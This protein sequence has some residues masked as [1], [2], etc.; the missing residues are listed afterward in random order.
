MR[1][2]SNLKAAALLPETTMENH[3]KGF[4]AVKNNQTQWSSYLDMTKRYLLI[5]NDLATIDELDPYALSKKE[6]A[7]LKAANSP[8]F[9]IMK[10]VCNT[11]Q[12]QHGTLHMAWHLFDSLLTD[13]FQAYDC[14]KEYLAPTAKIVC[15]PDFESGVVKIMNGQVLTVAEEAACTKLLKKDASVVSM[16]DGEEDTLEPMT[17]MDKINQQVES[18]VKRQKRHHNQVKS[19]SNSLYV[20]VGKLIRPTSNACERTFSPT[21]SCLHIE[22]ACHPR[23]LRLCCT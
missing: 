6:Q 21:T 14:M 2:A 19:S 5:W 8:H 18:F 3:G 15:S 4:A 20:D 7:I 23:P 17:M 12:F 16:S 11:L 1:K 9:E 13:S 22:D 10:T